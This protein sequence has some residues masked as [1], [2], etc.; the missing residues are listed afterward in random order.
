[1]RSEVGRF[2][3]ELSSA[4]AVPHHS[5]RRSLRWSFAGRL[6]RTLVNSDSSRLHQGHRMSAY[7]EAPA[8]DVAVAALSS[9]NN[10]ATAQSGET[11]IAAPTVPSDSAPTAVAIDTLHPP[12]VDAAAS[13]AIASSAVA[14]TT[15]ADVSASSS[16]QPSA[17]SSPAGVAP[18]SPAD[19]STTVDDSLPSFFTT[20][21]QPAPSLPAT[22]FAHV[23]WLSAS[24]L[25]GLEY[26]GG[27]LAD[28][29]GITSSPYQ[30]VI[31]AK[32]REER[33]QRMEEE[34][35]EEARVKLD[36]QQRQQQQSENSRME[37]GNSA[38]LEADYAP[39]GPPPLSQSVAQTAT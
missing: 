12:V 13:L 21:R 28:L 36:E 9:A 6:H 22:V 33:R 37:E 4:A 20:P 15:A 27:V 25:H 34:E 10:T 31:D 16:P 17:V 18:P 8:D 23:W 26:V 24:V 7:N 19:T 30:Y 38:A 11:T 5:T 3:V 39:A 14:H 29:L 32:E 2:L 35:E 1:M